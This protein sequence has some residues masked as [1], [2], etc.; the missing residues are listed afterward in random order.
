[1]RY[2]VPRIFSSFLHW[3]EN[4]LSLSYLLSRS[5]EDQLR[6][7]RPNSKLLRQT[8]RVLSKQDLKQEEIDEIANELQKFVTDISRSN[9]SLDECKYD[10]MR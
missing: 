7:L 6:I 4:M 10:K 8:S 1:M 3:L 2:H 9:K 5:T